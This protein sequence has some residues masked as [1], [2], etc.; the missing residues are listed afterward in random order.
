MGTACGVLRAHAPGLRR[1]PALEAVRQRL[2]GIHECL[3]LHLKP[4]EALF[5]IAQA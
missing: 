4:P 1:R 5:S 2:H 3:Y